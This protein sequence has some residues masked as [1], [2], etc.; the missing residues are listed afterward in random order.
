MTDQRRWSWTFVFCA[1]LGSLCAGLVAAQ[2]PPRGAA[3]RQARPEPAVMQV[4]APDPKL[5][6]ILVAWERNTAK[7]KTLSGE[8]YRYEFNDVFQTEKRCRGRFWFESPDKGRIDMEG[9]PPKEGEVSKMAD[10]KTGTPYTIQVGQEENWICNGQTITIVDPAQKQFEV[11][12]IPPAVQGD[13]IVN[14]PLPFLFGLKADE[15]KKRF[16]M[17]LVQDSEAEVAIDVI[18]LTKVDS[19]NYKQARVVLVKPHF[20]P[21]SVALIDPAG[22]IR[23][24]YYFNVKEMKVNDRGW[25]Q[26]LLGKNPFEPNLWGYKKVQAP[27]GDVQPAG[28][29]VPGGAQGFPNRPGTPIVNRPR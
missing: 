9:A 4:Q 26:I 2:Q 25:A 13:N 8:H 7:I 1:A 3:P 11:H 18:P 27:N 14:S 24:F 17:K 19:Q 12:E 29:Q 23:T 20:L 28:N 5:D 10:P 15:A 6:A 22:S 21:R 16:Q